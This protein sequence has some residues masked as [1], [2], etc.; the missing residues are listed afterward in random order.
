MNEPVIDI[1]PNSHK[2][3]VAISMNWYLNT[4]ATT[5]LIV[6]RRIVIL[7]EG[8]PW[9]LRNTY[10]NDMITYTNRRVAISMESYLC[11]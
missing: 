8:E 3:G 5:T 4:R 11:R 9:Q 10:L 1:V 6:Y 2:R 7:I